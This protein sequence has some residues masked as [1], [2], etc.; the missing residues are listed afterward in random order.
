MFRKPSAMMPVGLCTRRNRE[1]ARATR[2]S[3][4]KN[5]NSKHREHTTAT[6]TGFGLLRH[7]HHGWAALGVTGAGV[8]VWS[9]RF[10]GLLST[11]S[12]HRTKS[13][14]GFRLFLDDACGGEHHGGFRV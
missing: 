12:L 4:D 3:L 14:A 8:Q 13:E 10:E 2:T 6:T 11:E 9:V 7:P 5:N 1:R